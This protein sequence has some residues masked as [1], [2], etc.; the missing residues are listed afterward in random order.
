M[1]RRVQVYVARDHLEAHCLR[2][3]LEEEGIETWVDN[4]NLQSAIGALLPWDVAPRLFV[5]EQEAAHARELI[6]DLE[7]QAPERD[8]PELPETD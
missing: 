6:H 3:A 2:S 4:E 5:D 1:N 7:A 8:L